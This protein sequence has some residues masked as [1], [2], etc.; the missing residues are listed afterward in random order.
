MV[1]H[2]AL[3]QAVIF[4]YSLVGGI[5]SFALAFALNEDLWIANSIPSDMRR[6]DDR[7][8]PRTNGATLV[9]LAA[10][11][12]PLYWILRF[13]RDVAVPWLKRPRDYCFA[14]D[15]S[16]IGHHWHNVVT[17]EPESAVPLPPTAASMMFDAGRI[18]VATPNTGFTS[19]P[20]P[21]QHIRT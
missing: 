13:V 15:A 5:V 7:F 20:R 3:L 12:H 14:C 19:I 6:P 4:I 18:Q 9:R 11:T 17:R 1:A 21:A 16:C 2:S 10:W 8:P